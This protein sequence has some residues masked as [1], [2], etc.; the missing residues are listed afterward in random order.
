LRV[1]NSVIVE[2]QAVMLLSVLLL[3][4]STAIRNQ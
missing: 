1:P 2:I 3:N 4:I